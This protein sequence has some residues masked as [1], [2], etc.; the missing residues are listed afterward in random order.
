MYLSFLGRAWANPTLAWSTGTRASTDRPSVRPTDRVRPIHMIW[1]RCTCPRW[2]AE[3]PCHACACVRT[4]WWTVQCV[5][6]I[7]IR[8]RTPTM[9]KRKAETP[10]QWTVKLERERDQ[11]ISSYLR[12]LVGVAIL[13]FHVRQCSCESLYTNP[14]SHYYTS[15]TRTHSIL[16]KTCA[17]KMLTGVHSPHPLT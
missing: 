6:L 12:S 8:P 17:H 11:R 7:A 15:T 13:G 9:G 2:H 1:I 10:V 3:R 14:F 5:V 16:D 4:W